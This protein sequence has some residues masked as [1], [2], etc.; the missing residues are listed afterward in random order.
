[1]SGPLEQ[2]RALFLE[3]NGHF[4]HGRLAHALACFEAAAELA[5]GRASVLANLGV[6]QSLLGRCLGRLGDATAALHAFEQALGCDGTLAEA[7]SARG[8]L[9]RDAHRLVEAAAC[10]ERALAL[11]A[12]ENL[13]RFYLASVQGGAA[14]AQ[15]PRAYVET[16]F[17]QYAD[18]FEQ[19]LV[20][21]LQYRAHETLLQP[22]L[23]GRR[24]FEHVL[25][26][27]CG[28]GLCGRLI[29]GCAQTLDGVDLSLAM[30]EQARATGAY[31]LVEHG[32]LLPFLQH[33][34][35][36]VDLV[37]A[38][39]VF[40]YV[41]ALDSVFAAVRSRMRPGA[42]FAFTLEL[43]AGGE[44]MRLL[45]SLRYAHAPAYVHRLAAAHGFHVQRFWQDAIRQDQGLPVTGLFVYLE[46]F[47]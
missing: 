8:G 46:P 19:H 42:C 23:D 27:G 24:R 2:A 38:A 10:F 9:L 5:P 34:V 41:G 14:P 32:D 25:D 21:D 36:P 6:T 4:E 12:D 33:A 17:D 45:P 40:I 31:R 3:G 43:E 37:I 11:G 13:H 30:V 28:T 15:A 26:L 44:D 35:E 22:L 16:L 7:W 20:Q 29:R 18:A 1:M 39:D 47:A